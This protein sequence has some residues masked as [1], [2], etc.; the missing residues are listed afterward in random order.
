MFGLAFDFGASVVTNFPSAFF[1]YLIA[2]PADGAGTE[3]GADA[4]AGA[5]ALLVCMYFPVL[6]SLM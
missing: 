3:T 6:G 1:W 5:T 4:F 2:E